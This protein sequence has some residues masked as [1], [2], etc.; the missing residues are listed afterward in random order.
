MSIVAVYITM[1]DH[2]LYPAYSAAPRIFPL[3]PMEDQLLGGLIM[4]VPGG[5]I[6]AIIMSVVFFKW[7]ASGEDHSAGAQVDWKPKAA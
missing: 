4:W 1:S 5:L 2:I 3:S 6:F 7:S